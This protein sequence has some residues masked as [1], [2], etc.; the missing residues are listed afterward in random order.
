MDHCMKIEY[1]MIN[2]PTAYIVKTSRLTILIAVA[3]SS[4]VFFPSP[5][6]NDGVLHDNQVLH[7]DHDLHYNLIMHDDRVLNDNRD[8]HDTRVIRAGANTVS[9]KFYGHMVILFITTL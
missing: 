8:L 1:C 4:I 3:I 7:N 6:P 2:S 9:G 5:N